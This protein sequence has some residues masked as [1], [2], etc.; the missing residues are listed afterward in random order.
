MIIEQPEKVNALTISSLPE[1]DNVSWDE[2][3]YDHPDTHQY[4]IFPNGLIFFKKNR[5]KKF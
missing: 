5:N 1:N 2:F 4:T 3:V